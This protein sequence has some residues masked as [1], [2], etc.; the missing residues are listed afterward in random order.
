MVI[1]E[2]I[3]EEMGDIPESQAIQEYIGIS[4]IMGITYALIADQISEH[5]QLKQ[6]PVLEL[7][8]GLGNLTIEIGLRYPHLHV[9]GLDIS[10]NM[11]KLATQSLKETSLNTIEFVVGDAHTLDFKDESV[12]LVV[13]HGAMHH[14][15]DAK[16]VLSEI[17]RVLLPGGLAY[18]SDLRRDAPMDVVHQVTGL[19]SKHQATAFTNSVKAGYLPKELKDMLTDLC[20]NDFSI[21]EQKFSRKTIVKNMEKLRNA[22]VKSNSFNE[23][24]LNLIIQK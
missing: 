19:L 1:R 2:R 9:I 18:I 12:E 21:N 11:V 23:L 8:T 16:T 3:E 24:Y 6:G 15:M 17:H 20:I 4:K 13:S 10:E 22:T 7:G 14:W 5:I